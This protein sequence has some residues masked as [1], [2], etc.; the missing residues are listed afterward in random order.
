MATVEI[1]TWVLPMPNTN[2][3][4]DC[5]LSND[6]SRPILNNKKTTPNSAKCLTSLI[7]FTIPSACGPTNAPAAY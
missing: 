4:M 2:L 3:A 6:N 1:K 5:N 7:F